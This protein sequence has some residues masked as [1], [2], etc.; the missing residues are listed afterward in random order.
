M[1]TDAVVYQLLP[2]KDIVFISQIS[3]NKQILESFLMFFLFE[4][5]SSP[6]TVNNF[7]CSRF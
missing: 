5:N 4:L 1:G 7:P 2:H 3:S 6:G